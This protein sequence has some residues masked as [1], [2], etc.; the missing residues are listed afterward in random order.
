MRRPACYILLISLYGLLGCASPP[1]VDYD[2]LRAKFASD[3]QS[4]I[5]FMRQEGERITGVKFVDGNSVELLR[6]GAAAYPAML[7]AIRGAKHRIDME[8]Y[9]FDDGAGKLFAA[10]LLAR[11]KAG[12]EVNLIYDSWGS[13]DTTSDL[14]DRLRRGGVHVLE[15][16]PTDPTSII[17]LSINE[18]DHRKMLVIDGKTAFTGGINISGVYKRKL[19]HIFHFDRDDEDVNYDK[20]PWRDTEAKIEG[21][22]VAE[23][24]HLFMQTWKRQHGDDIPAPPQ[25]P[26]QSKG[27]LSVEVVDGTPDRDRYAIYKSLLMAIA[28]AQSS[29][30]LTTGFFVPTP[31]LVDALEEAAQRGVDVTLVL[32]SE[33]DSD[34]ALKAGRGY[35]AELMK[36]GVKIYER[37]GAVLHAKTSIIDGTWSMIGSSNL[38]WRSVLYNN[39]CNALILGTKFG[40]Q[41]ED[42]FKDDLTQSRH[43][44][45]QRWSDRSFW[46][47]LDE[48]KAR[49]VEN[50]L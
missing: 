17:D 38:D 9:E 31:D 47:S 7:K 35:Y 22:V 33:S 28:L 1:E 37:Q 10:A 12:V 14:F 3:P 26:T 30:H 4:H 27:D 21:P 15:Y 32:P 39:E 5:D 42:M 25:T 19:R 29:V 41:M 8:S 46:E 6:D 45:P 43:I 48:W 11:H 40:Q 23:F 24:E 20:L 18:R 34:L 50:L 36:A 2:S 13:S 49:Q 16:N 44:E